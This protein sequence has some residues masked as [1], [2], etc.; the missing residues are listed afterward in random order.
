MHLVNPE[1]PVHPVKKTAAICGR[2]GF[3]QLG[4]SQHGVG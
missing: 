1:N 2:G 3:H 4:I